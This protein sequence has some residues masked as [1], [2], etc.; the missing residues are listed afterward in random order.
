MLTTACSFVKF[1]RIQRIGGEAESVSA[2]TCG[3]CVAAENRFWLFAE[4]RS[5]GGPRADCVHL[6][7]PCVARRLYGYTMGPGGYAASYTSWKTSSCWSLASAI[8]ISCQT[9]I[10]WPCGLLLFR[11]NRTFEDFGILTKSRP[12]GSSQSHA[13][14]RRRASIFLLCSPHSLVFQRPPGLT[15]LHILDQY[16]K[17]RL[18]AD[19]CT[20]GDLSQ[21]SGFKAVP[22]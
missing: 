22:R 14:Q 8:R 3:I 1:G 10:A 7:T 17:A 19:Q 20:I 16:M 12:A 9:H 13:K 11:T 18:F 5:F 21:N 15:E 2:L 6:I 4:S